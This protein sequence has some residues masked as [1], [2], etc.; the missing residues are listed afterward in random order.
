MQ[1][2]DRKWKD[3]RDGI[4][5]VYRPKY[6]KIEKEGEESKETQLVEEGRTHSSDIYTDDFEWHVSQDDEE[7]V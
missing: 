4:R 1:I 2:Y 6:W 5:P 3:E 7:G